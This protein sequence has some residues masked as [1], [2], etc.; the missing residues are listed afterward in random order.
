MSGRIAIAGLLA[1]CSQNLG[2]EQPKPD[3]IKM[4]NQTWEPNACLDAG[5]FFVSQHDIERAVVMYD[6]GCKRQLM[7]A[8]IAGSK[9]SL[10]IAVSACDMGYE[11]ACM[12][13]A[14]YLDGDLP[15]SKALLESKCK[16]EPARCADAAKILVVRDEASALELVRYACGLPDQREACDASVQVTFKTEA[17]VLEVS[18]LGCA[19][20]DAESCLRAGRIATSTDD[21]RDLLTRSCKLKLPE[22]CTALGRLISK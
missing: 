9:Y 4:C 19:I 21:K 11:P 3:S 8:C 2:P 16:S 18:R 7:N 17:N 5:H 22:G 20:D 15:R 6:R 13:S 14:R 1:A 12:D 10:E